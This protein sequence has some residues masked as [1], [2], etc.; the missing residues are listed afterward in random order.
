[1]CRYTDFRVG[2][3]ESPGREKRRAPRGEG[4]EWKSER[5]RWV[6]SGQRDLERVW[7]ERRARGGRGAVRAED[8]PDAKGGA[9]SAFLEGHS[10]L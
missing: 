2:V 10:G 7:Q 1:M 5:V 9:T 3:K 8:L 4:L 6:Y